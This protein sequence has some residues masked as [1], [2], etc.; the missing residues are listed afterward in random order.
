MNRTS[1]TK[2][3]EDVL[4]IDNN[5]RHADRSNKIVETKDEVEDF[6]KLINKN[7]KAIIQFDKLKQSNDSWY[8]WKTLSNNTKDNEKLKT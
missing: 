2:Y 4:V 1:K 5:I 8:D 3:G 7:T 6:T